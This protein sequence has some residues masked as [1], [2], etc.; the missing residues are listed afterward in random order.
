MVRELQV[1]YGRAVAQFEN[2]MK[3]F[4]IKKILYRALFQAKGL[5]F[6]TF[7]KFEQHDD[8]SMIDWKASLRA[9]D[10]LA[11]QYKEERD[12]DIYFIVDASSSMLFGSDKK[13][14]S[15]YVAELVA[16]L[17][18]LIV[19]S[20]DNIG[21][22]MFTNQV[23]KVLP[24]ARSKNQFSLFMKFLSD[25]EYYGGDFNLDF[26]IDYVLKTVK[27]GFSVFILISD[28]IKTRKIC[29]RHLKLLGTRFETMAF[30]VRDPWD[31]ELPKTKQQLVIQD[32]YSNQ[33]MIIDSDVAAERYR[34]HALK[35]KLM[36][37]DVFKRSNIDFVD[38]STEKPFVYP[39]V[40]FLKARA[41]GSKRGE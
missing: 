21:L 24:P 16:A 3:K 15:E 34:L 39:L 13:L 4:P 20:G 27:G 9:N 8:A 14:K 30:M 35:Q 22:I 33:Q 2:A 38:L 11:K 36:L 26:V 1:N 17:S 40:T 10:M 5:E 25:A 41:G 29:E 18:Y 6:E 32:P 37:R 7:R 23:V 31:M 19:N 28:F 12:L